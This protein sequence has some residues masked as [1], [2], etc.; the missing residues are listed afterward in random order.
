MTTVPIDKDVQGS[1]SQSPT[2]YMAPLPKQD[3]KL[4]DLIPTGYSAVSPTRFWTKKLKEKEKKIIHWLSLN[5]P[6]FAH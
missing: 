2:S 4:N 5:I 3:V 6:N 1:R